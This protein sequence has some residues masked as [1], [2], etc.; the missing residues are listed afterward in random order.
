MTPAP[1]HGTSLTEL[2]V[3]LL[4]GLVAAIAI[5]QTFAVAEGRKRSTTG[6]AE[7]QQTGLLAM[8][9]VGTEIASAGNGLA[10][11]AR[12]LGTCPDTGDIR[13]SQRPI[14]ILIT[15][16]A[17]PDTP[18]SIVVN[19]GVA[20]A[21]AAPA[22]FAADAPAGSSYRVQSPL[23]LTANDMIVAI[24]L[25]GHC[26]ATT[27]T[28]VSA[29]DGNGVV[30]IQH[31]GAPDAYPASSM[32]LNRGQRDRVARVRYDIVD[33][34][35]RSLDLVNTG[36]T[37]NPLA[38][39]IVNM[40]AQYGIDSDNDEF[41]DTW[42]SAAT[43]AWVPAGVLAAPVATLFRIKAVRIGFIVRSDIYDRNVTGDFNWVMF[44]CPRIDKTQCTGR[45][46]GTLP[47]GWRYRIDET[48]IPLRN[49]IWNGQP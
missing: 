44:D 28:S 19:H 39:N 25:T 45:L 17:T 33:A 1:Q 37:P 2:M 6:V 46:A 42:V 36:A 21:H 23:G 11:A 43:A 10:A 30:E 32:L 49:Q 9:T 15:A 22:S 3:G 38:S 20:N 18:D 24:S 40:K 12:E 35:L 34:T 5:L 8:F 31:A 47:S 4:V 41:L 7:A 14:P 26:A 16:G 29:P 27:A 13:S 48:M